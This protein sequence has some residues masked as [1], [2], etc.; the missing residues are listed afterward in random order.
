MEKIVK[1]RHHNKLQD[2]LLLTRHVESLKT[3]LAKYF[4]SV[5]CHCQ[6]EAQC[7][8]ECLQS[9]GFLINSPFY[10]HTCHNF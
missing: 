5:P 2:N 8:E 6:P 1:K 9:E 4:S 7:F 3:E 10:S